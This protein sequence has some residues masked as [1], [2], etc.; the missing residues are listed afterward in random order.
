MA[1]MLQRTQVPLSSWQ[2]STPAD[3]LGA[4][5]ELND[6]GWR[7]GVNRHDDGTW[8]IELNK[9][10]TSVTGGLGDWLVLDGELRCMSDADRAANYEP[11]SD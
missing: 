7:G 8:R 3:M 4:L 5:E 2:L 6:L 10:N 9:S 11:A 1:I